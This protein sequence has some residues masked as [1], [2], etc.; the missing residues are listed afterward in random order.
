MNTIGLLGRG[1][2]LRDFNGYLV[3]VKSICFG[4]GIALQ[5]EL[6]ALLCRI[7]ECGRREWQYIC[8]H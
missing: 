2:I 6:Q 7:R 8:S 5:A 3:M 1:I 4:V